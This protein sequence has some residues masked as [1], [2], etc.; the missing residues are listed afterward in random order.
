M[1]ESPHALYIAAFRTKNSQ[2]VFIWFYLINLANCEF[3]MAG[4]VKHLNLTCIY[5]VSL[6]GLS[7]F[8]TFIV[9]FELTNLFVDW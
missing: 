1:K 6:W 8:H 3:L 4:V 9:F 7:L 5:M 2:L